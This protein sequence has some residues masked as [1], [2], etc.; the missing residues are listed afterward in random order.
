MATRKPRSDSPLRMLPDEAQ[1][2]VMEWLKTLPQREVCAKVKAAHG[3]RP[4]PAALSSFWSWYQLRDQLTRNEATASALVESMA[5]S[6]PDLSPDKLEE[7]GQAFFTALALESRDPKA[8]EST[9]RIGLGRA[10]LRLDQA[11]FQRETCSLFLKWAEDQRAK[12]IANGGASQS[13]KIAALGQLM[14]GEDW[15]A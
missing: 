14:F 2:E 4:S 8:W 11:K 15:K 12:E 5:E 13:D 9:Q 1:A 3:F 7:I 10:Q 6:N